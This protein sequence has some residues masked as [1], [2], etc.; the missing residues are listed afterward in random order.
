MLGKTFGSVIALDDVNINIYSDSV[1]TIVGENGAGKS[2]LM[3][4]LSG[5]YQ[6]YA[7]EICLDQKIVQFANPK[8]AMDQGIS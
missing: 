1:N 2:T 5:V 6:D 3:N 8:Q 4:I 7:G